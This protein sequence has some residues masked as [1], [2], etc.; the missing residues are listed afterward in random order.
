MFISV[1]LWPGINSGSCTGTQVMNVSPR[2]LSLGGNPEGYSNHTSGG[3]RSKQDL[4]GEEGMSIRDAIWSTPGAFP[5]PLGGRTGRV[6]YVTCMAKGQT[7][8]GQER[9]ALV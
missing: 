1:L 6:K 9:K 4:N 5:P 3:S 7:K 2:D 8:S